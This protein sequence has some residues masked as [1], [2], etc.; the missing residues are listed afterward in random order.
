MFGGIQP[1]TAGG[2]GVR[3]PRKITRSSSW[4]GAGQ[5]WGSSPAAWGSGA[6]HPTASKLS[7][8]NG[9]SLQTPHKT[10]NK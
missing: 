1:G 3:G 2:F 7:Q 6:F 4:A 10:G 8:A 5:G 9:A